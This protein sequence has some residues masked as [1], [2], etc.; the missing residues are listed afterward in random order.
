MET[1]GDRVDIRE[2]ERVTAIG[3]VYECEI[4]GNVVVMRH[5]GKGQLVCCAKPMKLMK[6]HTADEGR[7]KHVPMLTIVGDK[8]TI[9]VGSVPHPMTEQHYIEWVE[10]FHDDGVSSLK[11][12]APTD[13]PEAKFSVNGKIVSTRAYCN[14]HGLW[15]L[16]VD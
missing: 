7:E 3:Q 5:T 16:K 11:F 2:D 14:I 4:C 9:S 8:V 13:R 1:E 10:V 6:E 15:T 12:L